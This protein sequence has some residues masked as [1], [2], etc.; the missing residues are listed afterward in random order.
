[1]RLVT[2]IF[3]VEKRVVSEISYVIIRFLILSQD[4]AY[5]YGFVFSY[6]LEYLNLIRHIIVSRA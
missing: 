3:G 2:K 5:N 1:M 4:G 6:I